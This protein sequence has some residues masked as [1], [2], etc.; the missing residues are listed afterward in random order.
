MV[1]AINGGSFSGGSSDIPG[2]PVRNQR[3]SDNLADPYDIASYA[4]SLVSGDRQ[5]QYGHPLDNFARAAKIWEVILGCEVSPE[6][7]SLCMVG[8][9]IAREAHRTKPDTVVDGI[10]YFLTLAMISEERERRKRDD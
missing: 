9:K 4:A 1:G 8:M 5:A 7:V 2:E 10:G 3:P 6:Q